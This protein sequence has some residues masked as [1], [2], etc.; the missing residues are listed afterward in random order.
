M[1]GA[2]SRGPRAREQADRE[3]AA[4]RGRWIWLRRADE[5]AVAALVLAALVAI[6]VYWWQQGG[7]QGRLI[8]IDRAAP[9]EARFAVDINL[10]PWGELA[11]MPGIGET[12]AKRIVALRAERGPFVAH[13]DLLRVK[14]IGPKTLDRMRPFL[15]PMAGAD[16]A[17]K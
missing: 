5:P 12:L 3:Q 16:V 11:Q 2:S 6:G 10:A 1:T 7:W 4:R 14:G 17:R 13:E 8:E 15:L 9:L